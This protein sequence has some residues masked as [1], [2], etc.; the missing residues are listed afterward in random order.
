LHN[1]TYESNSGFYIEE[2]ERYYDKQVEWQYADIDKDGSLDLIETV[3][4][5]KGVDRDANIYLSRN[6]CLKIVNL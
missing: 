3:T 6:I 2:D 5:E 1:A 4:I